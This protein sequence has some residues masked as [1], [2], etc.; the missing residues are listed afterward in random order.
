MLALSP[1]VAPPSWFCRL[2]EETDQLV[3]MRSNQSLWKPPHVWPFE[4]L[5]GA[6]AKVS[7]L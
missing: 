6:L 2:G 3:K 4:K 7:N 1:S 5:H